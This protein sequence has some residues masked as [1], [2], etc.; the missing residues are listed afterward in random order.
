MGIEC[1]QTTLKG[2]CYE[3]FCLQYFHESTRYGLLSHTLI[4]FRTQFVV[5]VDSVLSLS[6]EDNF[7]CINIRE[8]FIFIKGQCILTVHGMNQRCLL[9]TV[10]ELSEVMLI[11]INGV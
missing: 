5:R 3:I 7:C 9:C 2:Q 8:I 10:K 4:F 11:R 6:Q 1:K